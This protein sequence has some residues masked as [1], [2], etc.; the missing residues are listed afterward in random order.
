MTYNRQQTISDA[1]STH[2]LWPRDL[3]Y[4]LHKT[5]K[6]TCLSS[7]FH[8]VQLVQRRIFKREKL[9]DMTDNEEY[10]VMPTDY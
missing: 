1:K 4:I 3:K 6:E 5:I 9:T 8:L 2:G 7:L 10:Q